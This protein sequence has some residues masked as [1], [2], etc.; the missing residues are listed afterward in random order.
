MSSKLPIVA[1]YFNCPLLKRD[2][3]TSFPLIY[4]EICLNFNW[5]V[6]LIINCFTP[7]YLISITLYNVYFG[8]INPNIAKTCCEIIMFSPRKILDY[9]ILLFNKSYNLIIDQQIFC[10]SVIG[11]VYI[12]LS[13]NILIIWESKILYILRKYG[14]KKAQMQIFWNHQIQ[15]HNTSKAF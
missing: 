5:V 14:G 11:R 3:F 10:L 2:I 1:H 7:F 4:Y 13:F 9:R 8:M 15:Y 6:N 12:H